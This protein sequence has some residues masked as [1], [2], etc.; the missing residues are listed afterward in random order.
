MSKLTADMSMSLDGFIAGAND[1]PALPLGEEGER[2]HQWLY[3]LD[4]WRDQHGL[5]GG[6]SNPATEVVAESFDNVGAVVMGKGMFNNGE[7]PWGDDPPFHTPVFV[8]THEARDD[9][10]KQGG[11]T[12]HFVTDGLESAVARARVASGDQRISVAGGASVV[13]QCIA[14]GLLEEIQIHLI[15]ILLGAGTRLFEHI[16]GEP[17]GLEVLRVVESPGVTHIRYRLDY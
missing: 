8:L 1:G 3:N 12:F 15:P 5:D 6:Q 9:L 17:A 16:E 11:T 13:Q 10:A 4:S 7:A 2:L 14:A